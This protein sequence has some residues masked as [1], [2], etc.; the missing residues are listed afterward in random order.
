MRLY[1][2]HYIAGE[3]TAPENPELIDVISASTEE[4]MGRVPSGSA[5][6]VDRAVSAAREAFES[7]SRTSVAARADFLERIGKALGERAEEMTRTITGEVGMPLKLCGIVQVGM[8]VK[9]FGVFANILREYRFEEQ[10][11]NSLLVREP[12]GVVACITPWN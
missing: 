11:G 9:N 3:W 12:V 4:V 7:W 6:D 5:R 2:K 8:P 1:D 10:V